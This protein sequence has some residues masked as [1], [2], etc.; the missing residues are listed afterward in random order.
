MIL[1]LIEYRNQLNRVNNQ[2]M[3]MGLSA[4]ERQE[5]RFFK[6][7]SQERSILVIHDSQLIILFII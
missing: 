2:N 7:S 1:N 4:K 5:P 6:R 3:I